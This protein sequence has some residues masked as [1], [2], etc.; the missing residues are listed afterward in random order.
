MATE[1]PDDW[2]CLV[3]RYRLRHGLTQ[4]RLGSIVGVSQRTVSRWE[5]G[6]DRPSL[7]VQKRLRDLGWE[8]PGSLLAS[9]AAGVRH[10]PLPRALSRMPR[11]TLQAVSRPA[12]EKRPSVTNLI[13]QDLAPLAC[14]VLQQMLDDRPLQ[15]GIA[16]RDIACVIATTRSVLRT[17]EHPVVGTWR[18]VITYF[19]HD[20]TLYSDAI[21]QRLPRK[22]ALGYRAVGMDEILSAG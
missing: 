9:L 19:S 11:L 13:G 3:S 2:A 7:E 15:A 1:F 12:V 18:T 10:S 21:S 4:A 16:S 17:A 20:G 14:G 22:T 8:T 6:E 5:R